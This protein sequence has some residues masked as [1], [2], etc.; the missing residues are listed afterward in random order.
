[1]DFGAYLAS[2]SSESSGDEGEGP[3]GCD[4]EAAANGD[5]RIQKY[6]VLADDAYECVV[7]CMKNLSHPHYE[8]VLYCAYTCMQALLEGC[9]EDKGQSGAE[10]EMEMTWEPGR[11]E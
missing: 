11:T 4:Q 3:S 9:R 6:K 7:L 2:S 5:D 1:M 10:E 8:C